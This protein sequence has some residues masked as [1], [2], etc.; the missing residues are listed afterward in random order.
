[1]VGSTAPVHKSVV[2]DATKRS[3]SNRKV[4]FEVAI[5]LA[6]KGHE[7][8]RMLSWH[9]DI[10][11]LHGMRGLLEPASTCAARR[12]DPRLCRSSPGS[13]RVYRDFLHDHE[14]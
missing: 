12:E 11:E 10:G 7:P 6:D 1:V 4:F 5:L 3:K 2:T 14:V 13:L 8:Y 9:H